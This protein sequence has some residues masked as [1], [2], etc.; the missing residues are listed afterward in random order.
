MGTDD[1]ERNAAA[2][3]FRVKRVQHM[4]AGEIEVRRG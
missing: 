4:R 1:A 3:K 2:R